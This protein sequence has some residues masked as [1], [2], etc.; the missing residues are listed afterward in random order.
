M[1]RV[2][3]LGCCDYSSDNVRSV[4]LKHF[5]NLGGVEAFICYG[6]TVAIKPNLICPRPSDC[7]AQTHPSFILEL[8]RILLDFGAKPIV[9]DSPAWADAQTCVKALGILDE[10]RYLGVEVKQLN[11]SRNI[12]VPLAN[13]KTGISSIILDVDKII[14]LPK[15]KAHQQMVVSIAIKNMFGTVVGKRKA[16]WHYRR[17]A[18][19]D[20]FSKL[21]LGVFETTKP[22]INI[23]DAV[24]AMESQGP[25]NGDSR[26]LGFSLASS[27][28]FACEMVC[29]K[30]I[31]LDVNE[32]PLLRCAIENG[33]SDIRFEDIEI[34]GGV[35]DDFA[36][37]DFVFAKLSPLR[38]TLPR[39]IR[40]I[41]RQIKMLTTK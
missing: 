37:D 22:T 8:A 12:V 21:L 23:I 15:L 34:V 38:F 20:E 19:V 14:N 26:E 25:I 2:S 1:S 3:L 7:A 39:I 17:G 13:A 24:V 4:M 35:I 9:C 16:I 40:S 5:E 30:I 27:D 36:V 32:I 10:L 11:K 18:S 33:L 28:A 31:G 29:A 6:D 41:Y